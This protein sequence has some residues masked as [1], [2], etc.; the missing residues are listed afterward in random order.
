VN[1]EK[2]VTYAKA[3]EQDI[4]IDDNIHV[5]SLWSSSFHWVK[6]P[7]SA[8]LFWDGKE[9]KREILNRKISLNGF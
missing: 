3:S 2:S 1:P 9:E 8:T 7:L 6:I 4:D 5:H